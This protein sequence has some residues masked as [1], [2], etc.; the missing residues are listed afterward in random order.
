MSPS[1]RVVVTPRPSALSRELVR[2]HL[3]LTLVNERDGH[4]IAADA[5]DLGTTEMGTDEMFKLAMSLLRQNTARA[6]LH[7]VATLP[8]LQLLVAQD[9]LAASRMALIPELVDTT[10]GGVV[11]AVPAA[12]QLLIVPLQ[13]ASALEALQVLASALGH[14]LD[15]IDHPLSDQLFWFDGSR[16]VPLQV[17]HGDSEITVVPPPAFVGT[18]NRL[19]AMDLVRVAAEA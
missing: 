11:V 5:E 6:D 7:P 1:L 16:W 8:G 17:V 10:L 18:M 12:D 3:Y 14:A 15:A 4:Y 2:G 9:G 13:S 19:A